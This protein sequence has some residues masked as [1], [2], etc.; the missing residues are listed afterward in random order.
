M[1]LSASIN[2]GGNDA[3]L[4]VCPGSARGYWF[5]AHGDGKAGADTGV[6]PLS[7]TQTGAKWINVAVG[8]TRLYLRTR[9]TPAETVSTAPV[10][11]VW[12]SDLQVAAG[13]TSPASTAKTELIASAKTLTST[14]VSG[15]ATYDYGST[16]EIGDIFG[17]SAVLV[18]VTTQGVTAGAGTVQIEGKFLT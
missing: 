18:Q 5:D 3:Q 1:A 7:I 6:A 17:C 14:K 13:A 16:I 10:V 15:D 8:V 11:S 12:G 2:A 4:I 9:F